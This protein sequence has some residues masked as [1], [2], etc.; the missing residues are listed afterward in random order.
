MEIEQLDEQFSTW[1]ALK[2]AFSEDTSGTI[3]PHLGY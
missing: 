2:S 3:S 1:G